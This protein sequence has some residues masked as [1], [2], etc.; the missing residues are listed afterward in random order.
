VIAAPPQDIPLPLPLSRCHMILEF[1]LTQEDIAKQKKKTL[2]KISERLKL[3][4]RG[5]KTFADLNDKIVILAAGLGSRLGAKT[6]YFNKSILKIGNIAA[7]SH[8]INIVIKPTFD[9]YPD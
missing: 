9:Y 3:Y 1:G 6:K 7:I 4:R 8:I 5:K 2:A